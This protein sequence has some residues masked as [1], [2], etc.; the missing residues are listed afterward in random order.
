MSLFLSKPSRTW[1]V[2]LFFI[3]GLLGSSAAVRA[4]QAA[5]AT[6]R[7][8]PED[9][10][11]GLNGQ[12]RNFYFLP[13]GATGESYESAGFFGQKLR[14]YLAGNTEALDNLNQYR[15]QKTLFLAERLV[16]VG[17]VSLYGQQVL[18]GDKKEYFN[19]T[20]QVALGVAAA[21][22]LTNILISRN[23]NHH[24]QRAVE[25]YNAGPP[26]SRRGSLW[27]RAQPT[28]LGLQCTTAGRPLLAL[29]WSLR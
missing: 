9:L 17:T 26:G 10:E 2:S 7:L 6:I 19:A 5:P 23:T 8:Q 13:P 11:R 25:A 12:Q 18:A 27:Q 1:P 16:F 15:R 3:V 22:L 14:P 20:Q 24:L 28:N 4:Q 29:G 21:S